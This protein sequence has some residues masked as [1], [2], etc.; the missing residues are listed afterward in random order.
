M[1]ASQA[2]LAPNT[3]EGRE[4]FPD[5]GDYAPIG[6][7]R[8]IALVDRSGSIEWLCLPHFSCPSIFGAAL[9]RRAGHFSVR[10]AV[11]CRVTR[12]YL[13]G[14][15][16]LQTSF[17]CEG[18]TLL[19]RDCLVVPNAASQGELEP[20]HE[21]LRE[22]HCTRGEV[23]V[24]VSFAP[25]PQYGRCTPRFS[26]RGELGWQCA[27]MHAGAF[28]RS[29]IPWQ[30]GREGELRASATLHTGEVRHVSFVF[31][32]FEI[33]AL[34]PLGAYA[35]LR[36]DQ[37]ARWWRE[38]SGRCRHTGRYREQ[39]IRSLLAIKLLA[40]CTSGAVMAA[41]STSLPEWIGGNR[42]WDYRFCWLRD[43]ALILDAFLNLGY[44]DEA[45][46]FLGWLLHATR[47]TWPKLQVMYDLYGETRLKEK[48]LESLS[49]YRGSRPVRI[50]NAA[51]EQLQLDIYGELIL[52]AERFVD[53]GGELDRAER[54]MLAGLAGTVCRLWRQPDH[55]I[56]E[57]RREPRHHTYS[58]GM[59]C[60]G[61]ES[62]CRMDQRIGLGL[63]RSHIGAEA[64]ELRARI[65]QDGFDATLG[66]YV[67]YFG[68]KEA[69]AS[70]L[71]LARHGYHLPQHPRMRGTYDFIDRSLSRGGLICR[72]AAENRYDGISSPDNAFAPC[73]FWAAEFLAR[74]G[75]CKEARV[76]FSRLLGTANDVGIY[77]E[78]ID[79]SD[80][81][82][83]NTPQGFTH[84]SMISAALA[85][86][87][88]EYS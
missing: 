57:T 31:D 26:R 48:E 55:G 43:S 49:G 76:L 36:I 17:D 16:V 24:D 47:L 41:A 18:G 81:P 3:G 12:A 37:T 84:V 66:A 13:P 82:V 19:L 5:I 75:R 69:D 42:N 83:G 62:L 35:R 8:S 71:L 23:P 40:C 33:C 77:A 14:S 50:G 72:F 63:D 88:A 67:G 86:D 28:I 78:E 27:G 70:I 15:N 34:P 25:R 53:S 60:L 1:D 7:C 54:N 21:L 22:L 59:C 38:W 68:G 39:V 74:A 87:A 56:W 10:P 29:D 45:E 2:V 80:R 4:V 11:S 61:L 44:E 65:E 58:K 30:P 64:K 20:Q 79:A 85:L 9:D 32:E 52:T 51:H 73:S 6:D 46:D